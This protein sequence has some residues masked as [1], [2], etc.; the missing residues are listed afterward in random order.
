MGFEL[1]N[2]V[3]DNADLEKKVGEFIKQLPEGTV[4]PG[5]SIQ[6][7]ADWIIKQSKEQ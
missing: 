4:I 5:E 1:A 7:R 2:Q 6:E 3:G